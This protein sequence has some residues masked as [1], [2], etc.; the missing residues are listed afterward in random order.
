MTDYLERK[1]DN[2]VVEGSRK[3]K[4]VE[5]VWSFTFTEGKWL[6]SN[7][8]AAS[9]SLEYIDMM[10]SVPKIEETLRMYGVTLNSK[11]R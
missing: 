1:S 8:D 10:K 11:R 7:I 6:V 3:K 2:K 4:D 5:R 9:S